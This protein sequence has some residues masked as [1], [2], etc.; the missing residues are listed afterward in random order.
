[1]LILIDSRKRRVRLN[2]DTQIE[3]IPGL[4]RLFVQVFLSYNIYSVYET[5]VL[6]NNSH[7]VYNFQTNGSPSLSYNVLI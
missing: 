6:L 4:Y 3:M 2:I 1:M 7:N 5:R